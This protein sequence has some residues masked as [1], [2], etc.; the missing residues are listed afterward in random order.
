[1]SDR[2]RRQGA[3]VAPSEPSGELPD[4][5]L[6]DFLDHVN[7]GAVIEGG[8]NHHL[9]M[10]GAAQDA[11]R[12][13]ARINTGYRTPEEVRE[14]LADLTGKP[15]DDSVAV[16]PPFYSEFG[17]NLTLGKD[18]FINSG[19]RFQDTGGITIGDGSLIGHGST[20]TTLNHGI[21]PAR[22][23]DTIPSPVTIGRKVWLGAGVTIVPGVTIGDGA[24]V[25]AG[26]VVTKDVPAN[27][28]VGGVPA[29]FIRTTGFDAPPG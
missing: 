10:H 22:R 15:I 13:V 26:S 3:A 9:F 23:A 12:I 1:M 6:Q 17:K 24:I 19:C 5:E 21:D 4:A 27:T 11:L 20:L 25:R 29:K 7:R 16:F 18:V 2:R 8:S 28:I 14:L